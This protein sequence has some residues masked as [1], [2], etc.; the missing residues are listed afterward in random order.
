MR[1]AAS[2]D[3]GSPP[4]RALGV[5]TGRLT[6]VAT[7]TPVLGVVLAILTWPTFSVIPSTGVDPSWGAGLYMATEGGLRFG[8]QVVFTYGPLGFLQVPVLY[9]QSLWALAFLHEAFVHIALAISLV[10]LGRRALPLPLALAACYVLLVVTYLEGAVVLLAFIWCFT[11]LGG[12]RPRFVVPFVVFAGGALSAIELLG[13][14]NFGIAVLAFCAITLGCLPDRRRN[15]PAFALTTLTVLFAAWILAGQTL[16]SVPDFAANGLQM[17]S[18]YSDGMGAETGA[19]GWQLPAAVGTCA[20]LTAAA[21]LSGRGQS[22]PRRLGAVALTALFAY[23]TFKQ[24]FVRQGLGSSDFFVLALGAA[25][26]IAPGLPRRLPGLPPGAVA[27]GLVAA[28][29]GVAIAALPTPSIWRSLDFGPHATP[30]RQSIGALFDGAERARLAAEGRRTMR[31]VYG[32]DAATRREI[33]GRSVD[34]EPWEVGVAWAYGLNWRPLPVMQ[35]YAAY[36]RHLDELNAAALEGAGPELILRH[37]A[38]ALSGGDP[39]AFDDRLEAWDPPAAHL[40][41]LCNYATVRQTAR[42][43]LLEETGNRCGPP[44]EIGVVRARSGDRIAVPA[45]PEAGDLVIARLSGVGVGGL[46]TVRSFLFRPEPRSVALDGSTATLVAATAGDGLLMRASRGT[47][48][49]GPFAIS[50]QA[51]GFSVEVGD[52]AGRAIEARFIVV[53]VDRPGRLNK[54]AV[55][56]DRTPWQ[57]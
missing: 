49:R 51:R 17:L 26:A 34:V 16:S 45:P 3:A 12:E 23:L 43:Q 37:A 44:R 28:L 21:F 41:M 18:G 39:N 1:A 5:R 27:A 40:A 38:G 19:F 46:E 53:H 11:A 36:T 13:K 7:S 47:D 2:I 8:E 35:G 15:L 33:G 24:S 50:P 52:G 20:A 9:D 48:Y 25:I 22:T 6:E 30:L 31:S 56:A 57:Q 14:L 32:L 29:A 4:G 54:P 10:W 55:A 42:W